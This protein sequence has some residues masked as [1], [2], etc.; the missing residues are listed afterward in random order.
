MVRLILCVLLAQGVL[1]AQFDVFL[2]GAPKQVN[3]KASKQL[4][5][6]LT[7]VDNAYKSRA[8]NVKMNF[9]ANKQGKKAI[10]EIWNNRVFRAKDL[11]VF[12]TL[13]QYQKGWQL[14]GLQVNVLTSSDVKSMEEL[15]IDFTPKGVLKDVRFAIDKHKYQNVMQGALDVQDFR[16]RQMILDFVENYRTAYD[17]KDLGYIQKVFNNNALII[18]GKV[19][20]EKPKTDAT[21]LG[22]ENNKVQLVTYSKKEYMK[23]LGSVFKRNAYIKVGFDSLEVLRHPKFKDWYGVSLQQS[24]S[25]S[26]YSD[27]GYLFLMIDFRNEENPEIWVRSWQPEKETQEDEIISMGDFEII[28]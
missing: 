28:E 18:V 8:K 1:F 25:S 10:K 20:K 3:S 4:S 17:R 19:L 16:R 26:S 15:V 21:F 6:F 14:R 7:S 27:E 12:G 2:K 5:D 23:Q 9:G 24:W 22:L 13:I 11:E